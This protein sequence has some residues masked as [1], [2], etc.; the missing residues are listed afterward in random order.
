MSY[1]GNS[2]Q[3]KAFMSKQKVTA[4]PTLA[5]DG[6]VFGLR[7]VYTVAIAALIY[8]A[9]LG[10]VAPD[11]FQNLIVVFTIS[12]VANL[13]LVV[14]ILI[15]AISRHS[16]W[17]ILLGGWAT[18]GA[19]LPLMYTNPILVMVAL[20]GLLSL[21]AIR[22]PSWLAMVDIIASVGIVV[23]GRGLL[24]SFALLPQDALTW[25]LP[26]IISTV[27]ATGMA[28][29]SHFQM[30]GAVSRQ[31]Q[32]AV[33]AEERSLLVQDLQKRTEA[34]AQ[35]AQMLSSS[36]NYQRV[37]DTALS[38]GR[39]AMY[40]HVGGSFVALVLLFRQETHTLYTITGKGISRS[41]RGRTIAG[42]RG[43]VSDALMRAEPVFHGAVRKDPELSEFAS[44]STVKSVV[45]VPLRAGY[46]NYGV[47]IFASRQE[48]AFNPD[49][50]T[51]LQAIGTQTTIALQNAALYQDL[52]EKKE[53]VIDLEKEARK[54][55]AND[56][57][58]G[59]TQIVSSIVQRMDIIKMSLQHN[60]RDVPNE[61]SRVKEMAQQA[62]S[63]IRLMLYTLRPLSLESEGGLVNALEQLADKYDAVYDQHVEVMVSDRAQAVLTMAQSDALFAVTQEAVNNARKHAQASI[64]QV[65]VTTYEDTIMLEIADDGV[66]FNVNKEIEKA[67]HRNS[68]GM[69]NLHDQIALLDGSVTIESEIGQGTTITAIIPVDPAGINGKPQPVNRKRRDRFKLAA[70]R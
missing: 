58:D 49:Y 48:D 16:S 40:D 14:F 6:A 37:L 24:T 67:H 8:Y 31:R 25:G 65:R 41:D 43:V 22:L 21:T 20:T 36:L 2:S 28:V 57:H 59:P 32:L 38:V 11:S 50:S 62:T 7:L 26:V 51:Y 15:P 66:G 34:I 4:S 52:V 46:D 18:L 42:R 68:L 63:E 30:R 9:P 61:V 60:P 29:M 55:L 44:L 64:I 19:F 53:N 1:Y 47:M 12:L 27:T 3:A 17:V 56:L 13:V 10:G 70:M 23:V 54:R 5:P 35:M 69:K 39:L 33:M 45:V